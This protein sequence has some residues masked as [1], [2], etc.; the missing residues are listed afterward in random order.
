MYKRIALDALMMTNSR[1]G[2]GNYQYNLINSLKNKPYNFDVYVSC[3]G[4]IESSENMNVIYIPDTYTSKKRLLFQLFGFAGIL[5]RQ[6]YDLVHFLDYMTPLQKIHSPTAVTIHDIGFCTENGYFTK[7]A[8][9]FKK[10]RLP[11]A[12]ERADKIITVS[13]FTKSEIIKYF[14]ETKSDKIMPVHLGTNISEEKPAELP[15][16]INCPFVL[17]VGTVEPRKNIISLIKSMEL[18]WENGEH[19]DLVI[20]GKFGWMYDEIL[21][22]AKKS[23]FSDKIK[24]TGFIS[25]GELEALYKSAEVFAFPSSYEGFGLP[26]LE[27]MRRGLAVVS[28]N[29]ASLPEILEDGAYFANNIYDFAQKIKSLT[30]N[31]EEKNILI[32]KGIERSRCFTWENTA[33]KT[34]EVYEKIIRSDNNAKKI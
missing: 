7:T 30:G 24:F 9:F 27:A 20:A 33:N 18:L 22:Y 6:K 32:Q 25:N 8:A 15:Q 2:V 14:P 5:N 31:S 29:T 4:I 26:P 34:I 23:R 11:S 21:A 12:L 19:T 28:S 1:A 13:E 3:K 16:N 10:K 17:F